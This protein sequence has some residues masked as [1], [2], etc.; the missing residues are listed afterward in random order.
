MA[1][2]IEE[3]K[4][5]HA[6]AKKGNCCLNCSPELKGKDDRQKFVIKV[7]GI[8]ATMLA[9]TSACVA[10]ACSS[11]ERTAALVEYWYLLY[12]F[13]GAGFLLMI[14]IVCK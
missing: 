10:V 9:F 7:Y 5:A 12:I 14:I 1:P 4:L 3:T 13:L 6:E 8:V 2:E 11:E